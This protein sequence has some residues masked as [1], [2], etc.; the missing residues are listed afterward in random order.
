MITVRTC[1]PLLIS[2]P[3]SSLNEPTTQGLYLSLGLF[4]RTVKLFVFDLERHL[5]NQNVIDCMLV[6]HHFSK[7]NLSFLLLFESVLKVF[8][9]LLLEVLNY[10]PVIE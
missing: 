6:V 3:T 10:S 7:Q 1:L 9:H 4:N 2:F 8:A 5:V